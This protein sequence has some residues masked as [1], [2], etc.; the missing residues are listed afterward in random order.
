MLKSSGEW[1]GD[2]LY[3]KTLASHFDCYLDADGGTIRLTPQGDALRLEVTGGGGGTD[4][5]TVEGRK[6]FGAVR[7]ARQRR[8]RVRFAA[9][10]SQAVLERTLIRAR[11]RPPPHAMLAALSPSVACVVRL[12]R[13]PGRETA[14]GRTKKPAWVAYKFRRKRMPAMRHWTKSLRDRALRQARGQ[15]GYGDVSGLL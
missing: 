6:D 10:R 13:R 3:C 15:L 11:A 8:P 9:R 1:Y 2:A 4:Q 12:T 14:L 5:I 7:S